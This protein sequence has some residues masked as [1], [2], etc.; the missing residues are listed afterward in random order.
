MSGRQEIHRLIAAAVP[1]EGCVGWNDWN[2]E[3]KA[4]EPKCYFISTC[5][6]MVPVTVFS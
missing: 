3:R 2:R 6:E 1:R 4:G 5:W